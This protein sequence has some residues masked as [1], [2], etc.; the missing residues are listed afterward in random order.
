MPNELEY[1]M[2]LATNIIIKVIHRDA[3]T[4]IQN[5]AEIIRRI[6]SEIYDFVWIFDAR[7]IA[8]TK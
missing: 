7:A 3:S 4:A 8:Q 2:L 6:N 1:E 5:Q